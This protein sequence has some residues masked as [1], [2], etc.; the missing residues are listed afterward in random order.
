MSSNSTISGSSDKSTIRIKAF[1]IL[2]LYAIFLVLWGHSIQY[3]LSSEPYEEPVYRI[4]YS[5]H[6]PL[7]MMISG[8]FSLS[9]MSQ[10]SWNFVKKKFFQLVL[11]C[12]SWVI[13]LELIHVL[14]LIILDMNPEQWGMYVKEGMIQIIHK[15]ID[16]HPFWF[17]KTCFAC[18]LFFKLIKTFPQIFMKK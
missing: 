6:M 17:L 14:H 12:F 1:D 8:Y 11:P 9:S 2:K 10:T 3:F 16:P 18:F 7:F 5:F 4:I 13:V 15:C